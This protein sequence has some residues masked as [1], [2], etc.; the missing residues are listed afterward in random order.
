MVRHKREGVYLIYAHLDR[1]IAVKAG[2]S[3]SKGQIFA[4]VGYAPY[5]GNWFPHVHVQ[6]LTP[7]AYDKAMEEDFLEL[8]GYG[9]AK[10]IGRLKNDF[11]DPMGYVEVE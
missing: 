9:A 11:P 5:N 1:D 3:L 6:V 10:D 4:T 2:Q 7:A 8:D